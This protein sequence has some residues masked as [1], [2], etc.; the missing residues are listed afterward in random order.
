MNNALRYAPDT[1]NRGTHVPRT[2]VRYINETQMQT[3]KNPCNAFIGLFVRYN[4]YT[5][6]LEWS[7]HKGVIKAHTPVTAA[8]SNHRLIYNSIL[9]LLLRERLFQF[10]SL[11]GSC[12]VL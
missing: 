9:T 1:V 10:T 2:S 4:S 6:D 12:P 11:W 7:R 8:D 5:P 3:E